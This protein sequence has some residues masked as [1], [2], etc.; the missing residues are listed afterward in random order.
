MAS[1]RMACID[2]GASA[3]EDQYL[4]I[5]GAAKRFEEKDRELLIYSE[6]YDK[7][8]RFSR[9]TTPKP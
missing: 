2:G 9:Q 3:Q 6:G 4:K 7:P 5:L 8:L 1:T